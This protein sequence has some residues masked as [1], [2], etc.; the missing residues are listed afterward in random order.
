MILVSNFDFAQHRDFDFV[1]SN[2]DFD[3]AQHWDC[4]GDEGSVH[5]HKEHLQ[6]HAHQVIKMILLMMMKVKVKQEP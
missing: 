6:K 1:I 4:E 3:Y 2:C 5:C